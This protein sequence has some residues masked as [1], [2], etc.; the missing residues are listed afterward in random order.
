MTEMSGLQSAL[1]ALYAQR[2]GLEVTG[3][4]VSN[5]NTDGYSR[6]RV[7]L[8]SVGGPAQAAIWSRY[9]GGGSG[10]SIA[11]I[12]RFRDAFLEIRA[13]VEHGA[14]GQMSQVRDAL[15][16]LESLFGEPSDNGIQQQLADLWSGFDEVANN[17]GDTAAR[18]QLLHRAATLAATF[19]SAA[20]ALTQMTRDTTTQLSSLLSDVNA[21]AQTIAQ[22]NQAI[23]ARLVSGVDANDLLDQRDQLANDLASQVGA[24]IRG[25]DF[26]QVSLTV[27]GTALVNENR[28]E[29]LDLDASGSP[30]VV[31]WD[32]DN[33][34]AAISSGQAGGMLQVINQTLPQYRTGIDAIAMQLRDDVNALQSSIGGTIATAAQDQSAAGNLQ[35]SLALNGGANATVTVAGANWSGAGGAAALQASMQ[36]AVNAAIGAGNA[37]VTV[38]GGNGSPMSVSL[39]PAGTNTLTVQ[40]TGT[41]TG[42]ATLLGD[43]A[44]GLDGVGGR[45]FFEGTDASNLTVSSDVDNNPTA[46]AAGRIGNGVL[47]NSVALLA[48]ELGSKTNGADSQYRAFIVALGVD[49]Q[50]TQQRASIQQKTTDAIDNQRDS[51]ASVNTDEEMVNLVQYQRAYQAAARVMTSIDEMLNTLINGTGAVGR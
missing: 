3:Q 44:V 31:R 2:R 40:A 42:F 17:A 35:F 24:T 21:K 50:S 7:N 49:S 36:A 43:T 23:K 20:A 33:Y 10:V 16:Q 22:L 4:N 39:V 30:V 13:A 1:S 46:V 28:A 6:Q 5:A 18:T 48:A 38:T 26:G 12:T 41:N 27:G 45:R 11:D 14:L 15:G 37:T 47:D 19:N 25:G 29:K 8:Q 32:K 34:P 51:L 9:S